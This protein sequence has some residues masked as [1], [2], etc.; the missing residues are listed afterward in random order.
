MTKRVITYLSV[1]A[2]IH[3]NLAI[4]WLKNWHPA[5][6]VNL[7][8]QHTYWDRIAEQQNIFTMKKQ[9]C[10]FHIVP[11]VRLDTKY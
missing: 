1:R 11:R 6:R 5:H 8:I 4:A 7:T 3:T 2:I 10:A 9:V